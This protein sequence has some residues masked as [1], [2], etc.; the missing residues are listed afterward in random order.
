MSVNPV[1][2]VYRCKVTADLTLNGRNPCTAQCEKCNAGI[3]AAF[4]PSMLHHYSDVLGYLD[5]GTAAP[6]DLVL[7][8]CDLV[9]VC[10]NCSKEGPVKVTNTLFIAPFLFYDDESIYIWL[11]F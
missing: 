10:L 5:L 1:C 11:K 6:V 2:V 7:Q 8:D 9:I 4:R 3:S